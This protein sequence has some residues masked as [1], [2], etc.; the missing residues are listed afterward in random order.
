MCLGLWYEDISRFWS[1]Y[2]HSENIKRQFCL[3]YRTTSDINMPQCFSTF[4]LLS[5]LHLTYTYQLTYKFSMPPKQLPIFLSKCYVLHVFWAIIWKCT[6]S[7]LH[8][9]HAAICLK[10]SIFWKV[11]FYITLI[12]RSPLSEIYIFHD[13]KENVYTYWLFPIYIIR[14][15]FKLKCKLHFLKICWCKRFQ[16]K[17]ISFPIFACCLFFWFS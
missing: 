10:T 15:N 13:I 4:K 5:D 12:S 17:D 11:W 8:F 14:I 7:G 6:H 2:L 9:W 3:G 16:I 1:F